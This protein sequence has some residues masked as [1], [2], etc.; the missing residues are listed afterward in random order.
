VFKEKLFSFSF[1]EI[2]L[3]L[4]SLSLNAL[5][6]CFERILGAL[7]GDVSTLGTNQEK[8]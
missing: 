2:F 4:A 6:G 5:E 3:V 1:A 7:K 8:G